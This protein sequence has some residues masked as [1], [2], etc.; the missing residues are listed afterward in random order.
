MCGACVTDEKSQRA[1]NPPAF[2]EPRLSRSNGNH[3]QRES[4]DLGV[5]A[6]IWLV[7][8]GCEATNLGVF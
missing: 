5:F 1:P 8:P 6:P 7:L 4:T 3:P 2:A